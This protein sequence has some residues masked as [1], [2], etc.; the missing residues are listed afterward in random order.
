M[1]LPIAAFCLVCAGISFLY[2]IY[3]NQSTI[4]GL[5]APINVNIELDK[6]YSGG[7][8]LVD[9][10]TGYTRALVPTN[11]NKLKKVVIHAEI[12]NEPARKIVLRAP[13]EQANRAIAS[14]DN[15]SV[16]VGNTLFYFDSSDIAGWKYTTKNDSVDYTIPLAPY[17]KSFIKPD[18]RINWYGSLNFILTETSALITMPYKF[19]L[20]YIFGLA[21]FLLFRP[22]LRVLLRKY[23]DHTEL[24]LLIL[25]LAF[26]FLLRINVITRYS[27]WKDDLYSASIASNPNLPIISTFED[28]GNPPFFFLILRIWFSIFGWSET[29]GRLLSVFIGVG[30]IFT[31]Y[32]F[33]KSFCGRK[34]AFISAFLLTISYTSLGYSNEMRSYIFQIMLVPLVSYAF[35]SL[36]RDQK[37][38]NLLLYAAL[39]I[40][41]V[42]THYYGV[43]FIAGNFFFYLMYNRKAMNRRN[44]INFILANCSIAVS[45]VPYLYITAVKAAFMNPSFN[46]WISKLDTK[47]YCFAFLLPLLYIAGKILKTPILKRHF[48]TEKKILL[49][50]YSSFLIVFV[51]LTAFL[52]SLYRPIFYGKYL[53]ICFPLVITIITSLILIDF[54]I[55]AGKYSLKLPIAFLVLFL[56]LFNFIHTWQIFR[57]G[58]WDVFKESQHYISMDTKQYL[59]GTQIKRFLYDRY[60]E[61]YGLTPLPAYITSDHPDVVYLNP[62][63]Y[64]SSLSMDNELRKNGLSLDN[65]LK[66]HVNNEKSIYKLLLNL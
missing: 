27:A 64:E 44:V 1:K 57:G 11:S 40:V 12:K 43:L 46:S 30:G 50:D 54:D 16:F 34:H 33:V 32:R 47:E 13:L 18:C 52:I 35:F 21:A 53:S 10:S 39:G 26:G 60:F 24:V 6:T 4:G 45:L 17:K 65:L 15:V 38:K 49:L 23:T 51:Y 8:V 48:L 36:L 42:N 58:S 62:F 59:S 25:L 7:L 22:K 31:L 56:F 14:I 5:F 55:R 66:I 9:E 2:Y 3:T 61:F 20:V 29:A 28:P 63:N 41:L 19:I 37:S